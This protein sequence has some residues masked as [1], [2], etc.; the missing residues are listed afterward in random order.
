[1]E[2]HSDRK[3]LLGARGGSSLNADRGMRSSCRQLRIV[4]G[5]GNRREGKQALEGEMPWVSG[6][7]ANKLTILHVNGQRECGNMQRR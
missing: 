3:G 4:Y 6:L 7:L 2:K 5:G 1:M